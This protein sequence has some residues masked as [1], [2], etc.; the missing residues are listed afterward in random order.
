VPA[1]IHVT[2]EC[3]TGGALARV[4]SGDMML[5]DGDKGLLQAQVAD[6]VWQARQPEVADLSDY[7]HGMGRELFAAFRAN[8]LGAEQGAVTFN[9]SEPQGT[10]GAGP[11]HQV[12]DHFVFTPE[13]AA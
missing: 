12:H 1:A 10:R 9:A 6:A 4:R 3:L 13:R 8:A 7:H 11:V 5:L 2:P